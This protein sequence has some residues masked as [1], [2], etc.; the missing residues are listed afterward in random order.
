MWGGLG[1]SGEMG[2]DRIGG[3]HLHSSCCPG[4]S[5]YSPV[6]GVAEAIEYGD[7]HSRPIPIEQEHKIWNIGG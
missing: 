5:S 1:C 2:G 7:H 3:Q 6:M 4:S